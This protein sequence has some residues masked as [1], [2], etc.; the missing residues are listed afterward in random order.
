MEVKIDGQ[1][2]VEKSDGLISIKRN[3]EPKLVLEEDLAY[4]MADAIMAMEVADAK[5]LP[6]ELADYV[7]MAEDELIEGFMKTTE[8]MQLSDD[9]LSDIH[10]NP[11]FQNY[12]EEQF[13][14]EK[15]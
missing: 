11:D 5:P 9:D 4:K 8:G 1:Y 12:C 2:G 10:D 6:M 13:E 3:G 14:K 7:E 15:E